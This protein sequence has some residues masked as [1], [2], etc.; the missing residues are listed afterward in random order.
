MKL[1]KFLKSI[2]EMKLEILE[3]PFYVVGN[4]ASD[5]D[6]ITSSISY[7]YFLKMKDS[8]NDYIP[9]MNIPRED[10]ALR[11]ETVWF[12]K[13]LNLNSSDLVFWPELKLPKQFSLILTD[14]N[15]LAPHQEQYSNHVFEIID[16]HEDE[17]KYSLKDDFRKI[18]PVGSVCSLIAEKLLS[19]SMEL[20]LIIYELLIGTILIDTQN[21]DPK[22]TKTKEKDIEMVKKLNEK[23]K[24]KTEE[25]KELYDKLILERFSVDSLTTND[26]LRSDYKQFE[27]NKIIFGVSSIKLSLSKWIEKD[28]D[29]KENLEIFRSKMNLDVLYGM[30]SSLENGKIEKFILSYSKNENLMKEMNDYLLKTNLNMKELKV[31]QDLSIVTFQQENTGASRKQLVPFLAEFCNKK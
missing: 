19:S 1:A 10:F 17:K 23:C 13:K 4:E 18:E 25:L 30:C 28:K 16:H 12:F 29:L 15:R 8:K 14:H 6:S 7:A 9:V 22:S 5:L 3:N 20:D 2:K 26:L 24:F 11:T 31:I 21:L 27:I